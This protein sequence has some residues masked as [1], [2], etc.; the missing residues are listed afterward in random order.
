MIFLMMTK[1]LKIRKKK[2]RKKIRAEFSE[3]TGVLY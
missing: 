3:S 2:K 1:N